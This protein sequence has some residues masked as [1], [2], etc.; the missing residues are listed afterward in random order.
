VGVAEGYLQDREGKLEE[1]KL[2]RKEGR[3]E[4]KHSIVGHSA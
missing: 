3:K 2:K 4:G 1:R